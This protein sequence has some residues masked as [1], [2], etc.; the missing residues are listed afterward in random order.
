M[1]VEKNLNNLEASQWNLIFGIIN[2]IFCSSHK[3]FKIFLEP[4]FV[5][6]TFT[7][8]NKH[9]KAQASGINQ[10]WLVMVFF[11][12][13]NNDIQH[14]FFYEPFYFLFFALIKFYVH[15]LTRA[16]AAGRNFHVKLKVFWN[17]IL[18]FFI[19]LRFWVVS[20]WSCWKL[21]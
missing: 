2:T 8:M 10:K 4:G 11:V 13:C 16:D 14:C 5:M 17:E 6:Q 1:S 7:F 9:S 21:F 15:M 3:S 12:L 18:R 19:T 20:K